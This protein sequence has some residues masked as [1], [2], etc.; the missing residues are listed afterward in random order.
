MANK[1][2][3]QLPNLFIPTT[4]DISYIVN[5]SQSYQVLTDKIARMLITEYGI[6]TNPLNS[7]LMTNATAEII[8]DGLNNASLAK[9]NIGRIN[10]VEDFISGYFDIDGGTMYDTYVNASTFDGGNF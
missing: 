8:L 1:T 7:N 9:L 2:L 6:F 10:G 5:G 3:L 4:G